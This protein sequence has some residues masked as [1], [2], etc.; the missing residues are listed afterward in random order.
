MRI[1]YYE[2]DRYLTEEEIKDMEIKK[3]A[4]KYNL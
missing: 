1:G 3:N 2:I 4:G